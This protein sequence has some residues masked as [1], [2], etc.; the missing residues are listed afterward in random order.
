MAYRD[1]VKQAATVNG[2]GAFTLGAAVSGYQT[3][4]IGR[5]IG[6]VIKYTFRKGT[7]WEVGKGALGAN[8]VLTRFPSA[9]SNSGNLVNFTAGAGEIAETPNAADASKFDQG[10]SERVVHTSAFMVSDA[11]VSLGSTNYGTDQGAKMQAIFDLAQA[12]PLH[13]IMDGA[14][15]VNPQFADVAVK[16]RSNTTLD[17]LDNCGLIL[18]GGAE[19]ALLSNYDRTDGR[20]GI[21]TNGA[22]NVNI[23]IRGGILNGAGASFRVLQM[24]GVDGLLVD[25][26]RQYNSRHFHFHAGN[27]KNVIVR[28]A[29]I[30]KGA[31]GG[32]FG[33]GL[34]FC[35]PAENI[36]VLNSTIL[37]CGDDNIAFNADDA[38]VGNTETYQPRGPITN[39]V[40]DGVW[41]KSSLY[42]IRVLSGGSRVDNVTISNVRGSTSGYAIVVDNFIPQQTAQTGAGNIGTLIFK[43]INVDVSAGGDPNLKAGIVI[44]CKVERLVLADIYRDKFLDSQYASIQFGSKADIVQ[45]DIPNYKGSPLKG[46]TSLAGQINFVSGSKI[47]QIRVSDGM[48]DA[49]NAVA[50]YPITVQPGATIEQFVLNGNMA[51]N[52]SGFLSN[53]GT[54]TSLHAPAASNF[55]QGA[56]ADTIAPTITSASV[57][58]ASPTV[59]RLVASEALDGNFVP[60][61]GSFAIGGHTASAVAISGIYM[62][63]TVNAFVQGEA[64]RTAAYTQPATNGAR[65]LSG[66]LMESFSARAIT[67]NVGVTSTEGV[68]TKEAGFTDNGPGSLTYTGSLTAV[69]TAFKAQDAFNGD[70]SLTCDIKFTGQAVNALNAALIVR[71]V[72][73]QP[74]GG[75]ASGYYLDLC[76]A[77]SIGFTL[78][79]KSG[80][81]EV[82]IAATK[83]TIAMNTVYRTS[84][85]PKGNVISAKV[86]RRSDM[87]WLQADGSWGAGEV[88]SHTGTDSGIVSG[89]GMPYGVYGYAYNSGGQVSGVEYTNFAA[90]AAP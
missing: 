46:G 75:G 65:D 3:M 18:R 73:P 1:L 76:A 22:G 40:V 83:G 50:G 33:D 26:V 49:P 7:E 56:A 81:T 78:K 79:R 62:D 60:A 53:A 16:I 35:G 44:D 41:F 19:V 61:P 25:R 54:I 82:T 59:V 51:R 74:W 9:S 6:T 37:N 66:N 52:F 21:G 64:A 72:T 8:G 69:N 34:H 17:I 4:H 90:S 86:Q 84:I 45:V 31:G 23:T 29:Y 48:F 32:I 70:V 68:W 63:V 87:L 10:T 55:M 24:F 77:G 11:D 12:G 14:Y 80:G 38:W 67:N 47:R 15:G 89:T 39:V 27:V 5:P 36:Q 13:I 85:I 30:D 58:D 57:A 20:A 88:F 2:T 71:G 42:G 28:D 43:N